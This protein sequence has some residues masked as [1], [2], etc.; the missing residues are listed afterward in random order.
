[1]S[2]QCL[3]DNF[4]LYP[5]MYLI[6]KIVWH[7]MDFIVRQVVKIEEKKKKAAKVDS[8]ISYL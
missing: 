4:N 2:M 7:I 3:D 8:S 1:M 6:D 5:K